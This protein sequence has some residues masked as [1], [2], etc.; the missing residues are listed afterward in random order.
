MF[1][2]SPFTIN[3]FGEKDMG[4]YN[5]GKRRLENYKD[6][7][8]WKYLNDEVDQLFASELNETLQKKAYVSN[9]LIE[10]RLQPLLKK[11]LNSRYYLL[12]GLTGSG[13]TTIMRHV[14]LNDKF[15]DNPIITN[16]NLIIPFNF[17]TIIKNSKNTQDFFED[18]FINE[19]TYAVTI[20]QDKYNI[21][22]S[23][24]KDFVEFFTKNSTAIVEFLKNGERQ[25]YS[26][27]REDVYST[28][29][30]YA[31]IAELCI[32]LNNINCKINN[33]LFIVD[34]IESMGLDI[35]HFEIPL[36][37]AHKV[38]SF[39]ANKSIVRKR[40]P[41]WTPN[42]LI[43][44]R[45]YVHRIINTWCDDGSVSQIFES[46][47]KHDKIDIEPPVSLVEIINKRFDAF[48]EIEQKN[49]KVKKKSSLE[50]V[51]NIAKIILNETQIDGRNLLLDLNLTNIR[52]AL[53][54][55]R[56]IIYNKKW[57]QR[58]DFEENGVFLI[59]RVADFNVRL[60]YILRAIGMKCG[61]VY[62]SED[63]II[64]NLLKNNPNDDVNI[65][66]LLS[67][68]YFMIHLGLKQ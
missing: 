11:S 66:A 4:K 23:S 25:T 14:F 64:P 21:S 32:S 65:Y 33:V 34:N 6:S 8:I 51:Y 24:D 62:F 35:S 40:E 5:N 15:N 61:D 20:I 68:N 1:I 2:K 60:P 43:C 53:K 16:R 48:F 38:I 55:L 57:I 58:S 30:L 56:E 7:S 27:I 3:Y 19:I 9:M 39:M 63:C 67:L 29:K 18:I 31:V 52:S 10:E 12:S 54:T 17:D 49:M 44:C 47:C 13:K 22:E 45:H 46:F 42:I 41:K 28:H 36:L 59:D 50:V 37:T 26:K